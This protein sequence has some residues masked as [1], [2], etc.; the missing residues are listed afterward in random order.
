MSRTTK[1]VLSEKGACGNAEDKQSSFLMIYIY[2]LSFS[3]LF[4]NILSIFHAFSQ[5]LI[6]LPCTY[7]VKYWMTSE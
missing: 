3:Y 7:I 2:C 4:E 6:I 5:F 1:V